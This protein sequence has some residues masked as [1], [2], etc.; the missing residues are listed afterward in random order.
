MLKD[1]T[2]HPTTP[3]GIFSCTL[4]ISVRDW[5]LGKIGIGNIA[6]VPF[7]TKSQ[8]RTKMGKVLENNPEGVVGW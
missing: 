1:K 6:Q 3:S 7:F 2:H 5:L 8:S 4:P